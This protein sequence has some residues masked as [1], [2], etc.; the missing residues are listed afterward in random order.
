MYQSG[1]MLT[2]QV[3]PFISRDEFGHP[4]DKGEPTAQVH[5]DDS[6][7]SVLYLVRQLLLLLGD[8]DRV[9]G[10]VFLPL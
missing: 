4:V 6:V 10:Y 9:H 3:L 7:A 1:E 5:V 8:L 2:K